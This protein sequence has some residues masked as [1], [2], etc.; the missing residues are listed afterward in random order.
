MKTTQEKL[1]EANL[2]A[3][4][5]VLSAPAKLEDCEESLRLGSRSINIPDSPK[6]FQFNA[7]MIAAWKLGWEAGWIVGYKAAK[8]NQE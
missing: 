7:D 6:Y 4:Y 5:K 1:L 8:L 2:D 3:V